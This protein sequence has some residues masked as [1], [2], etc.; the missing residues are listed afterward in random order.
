MGRWLPKEVQEERNRRI[1]DLYR[2]GYTAAG[3]APQFRMTA[4]GVRTIL[5]TL[6]VHHTPKDIK[7]I[8]NT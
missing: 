8:N 4:G 7:D 6:G 5:A 1:V 2:K 3:I